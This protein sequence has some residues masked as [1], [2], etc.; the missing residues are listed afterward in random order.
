MHMLIQ[1]LWGG[2]TSQWLGCIQYS[3]TLY[4]I[5]YSWTLYSV[6]CEEIVKGNTLVTHHPTGIELPVG[7][8]NSL[9]YWNVTGSVN[10]A[11]I[12]KL[13]SKVTHKCDVWMLLEECIALWGE[14]E[15]QAN[16]PYKRVFHKR[17]RNMVSPYKSC[18]M[19]LILV[20][21]NQHRWNN[22]NSR[23][24]H[25]RNAYSHTPVQ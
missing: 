8:A 7:V 15:W 20:Q 9:S 5:Q 4:S 14:R 11:T 10:V 23:L 2:G 13:L 12:V 1:S 6:Y 16:K 19:Q 17:Y 22:Y 25:Y 24:I 21:W 18:S 3:C